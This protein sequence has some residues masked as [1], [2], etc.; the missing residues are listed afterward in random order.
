MAVSKHTHK[1][2]EVPTTGGKK[3]W[4]CGNCTHYMPLNVAWQIE[5]KPSECWECD[6][7]VVMSEE[8]MEFAR[9]YNKGKILCFD[10]IDRRAGK[11]KVDVTV[12]ED[13]DFDDMIRKMNRESK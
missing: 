3:L 6:G 2:Q 8:I 13:F 9:K 1:Y 11:K 5:G 7:Q 12:P 4:A 10:C